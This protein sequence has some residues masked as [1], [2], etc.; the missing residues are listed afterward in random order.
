MKA[1]SVLLVAVLAAGLL[2]SA[3]AGDEPGERCPFGC[4]AV[5][6]PV[7]GFYRG[8]HRTF[9]NSCIMD[10]ENCVKRQYW[11]KVADCA[12]VPPALAPGK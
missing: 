1:F 8:V 9:S 6:D 2:A 12:C 10:L 4:L 11:R 3:F 7:C 5:E